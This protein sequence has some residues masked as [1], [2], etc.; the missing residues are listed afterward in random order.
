MGHE[1]EARASDRGYPEKKWDRSK[2]AC[3]WPSGSTK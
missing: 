2:E 1:T 3:A